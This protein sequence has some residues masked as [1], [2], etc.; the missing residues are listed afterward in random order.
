MS[1][2]LGNN[3]IRNVGVLYYD[4]QGAAVTGSNIKT[5][6]TILNVAGTYTA[7]GTQSAGYTLATS[8]D[9]VAGKSAW[10]NGSEVLGT[11]NTNN[12][13]YGNNVPSDSYGENGDVYL[14]IV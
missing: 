3:K 13:Y 10:A 1:V 2:Y 4:G 8:N 6:V 7:S 12:Y 14:R 5:G 11:L 9:I